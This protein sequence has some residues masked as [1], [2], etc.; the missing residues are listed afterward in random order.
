MNSQNG[1]PLKGVRHAYVLVV[2]AGLIILA[3]CGGGGGSS[4]SSGTGGSGGGGGT[5]VNNTATMTVSSGPGNS[6]INGLFASVT[7]CVPGTSNCQTIPEVLVDTGSS[8]V[9]ILASQV[10]LSLPQASDGSGNPL[11]NCITFAD[12]TFVWGPVATADVQMA[13]EKASSVPIQIIGA[14]GFPAVPRDCNTGGT[15]DDTASALGANGIAGVGLFRQD[16]GAACSAAVS[17]V[18]KVYFSCPSSGCSVASVPLQS[19]VQNPVWLFSQ[20]NNGIL[21]SLPSI[22]A[23]GLPTASGSLIFGIG[24]Q[25]DNALGSAKVYTTDGNGNFSTTFKGKTYAGSYLDTG[26]NG[27][28]FLGSSSIGS[29][30]P[31]CP[32][33]NQD[34][35]CPSATVTA[36]ATNTG[37]NSTSA[38]ISFSIANADTLF[39][40]PNSAFNDL[41]G[42]D[43]GEFDW[44]LPFFFGRNVFV[45]I[46]SQ[47][48]PAGPGPFWAY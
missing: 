29:S 6:T 47:T 9:R 2:S 24:T 14:P 27:I 41:G 8:G 38:Q 22:P 33:P 16:C 40:T 17:Q 28:F 20:D 39:S 32:S 19:Q 13:G 3:A 37:V 45:A 34:F 30:Y 12:N 1:S 5:A 10:S 23:N 15:A 48:T 7:L 21:I 35:S 44:G 42:P 43:T 11:G 25:S 36:S 4:S 46:E 26:S 31:P 18:P